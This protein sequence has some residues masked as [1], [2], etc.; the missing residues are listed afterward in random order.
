VPLVPCPGSLPG[1][2]APAVRWREPAW[3]TTR[4]VILTE[5]SDDS[6]PSVPTLMRRICCKWEQR[7]EILSIALVN[8]VNQAAMPNREWMN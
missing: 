3:G 7:G 6:R 4:G 1:P 5:L 2:A 8:P